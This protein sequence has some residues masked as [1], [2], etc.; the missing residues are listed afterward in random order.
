[1]TTL[2]HDVRALVEALHATPALATLAVTG[3]GSR[4]LAWL[5]AV[6]GASRTVLEA[7]VPYA[8]SSAADYIGFE[9]TE[10]ASL[11]V[12]SAL[13][14]SAR[15]RSLDLATNAPGPLIGLGCA[16]AIA[17]DRTK[18]GD[19]RAF[20]AIDLGTDQL[21]THALNLKKGERDRD[22]EEDLVSRLI[23]NA[24]AAASD[25][26]ARLHLPLLPGEQLITT[27]TEATP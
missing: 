27:P 18:R 23:L 21:T 25:L 2:D 5:L 19:H 14:T 26:D 20:V 8:A 22:A 13:A 24:L 7:T 10:F 4:G 15:R 12:A 9:P 3:A 17:T 1:M 6:G 11:E 16:A